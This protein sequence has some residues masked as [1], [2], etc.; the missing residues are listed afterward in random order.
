MKVRGPLTVCV[1]IDA[2]L[3]ESHPRSRYHR[4]AKRL[5]GGRRAVTGFCVVHKAWGGVRQRPQAIAD[6]ARFVLG[7]D[8]KRDVREIQAMSRWAASAV[9]ARS[10]STHAATKRP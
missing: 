7:Q 10:N 4:R 1:R 8:D 6:A 5:G 9:R 3:R 2:R